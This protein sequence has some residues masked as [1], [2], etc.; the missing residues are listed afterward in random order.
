MEFALLRHALGARIGKTGIPAE[1]AVKLWS[2]ALVGG[3]AGYAVKLAIGVAHPVLLAVVVLSI[4]G[5]IYF[6]ATALMDIPEST[7]TVTGLMRRTGMLR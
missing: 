7:A 6:G 2:A 3:A 4:Y 5:F 1:F